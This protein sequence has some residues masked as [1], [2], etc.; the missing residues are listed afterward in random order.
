[1][2]SSLKTYILPPSHRT[3]L[4]TGYKLQYPYIEER[5]ARAYRPVQLDEHQ[6]P[7]SYLSFS[8]VQLMF[9]L[10]SFAMH[11]IDFPVC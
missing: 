2:K 8:V 6:F 7:V 4:D 9:V 1:M 3:E 5:R 11:R 10:T